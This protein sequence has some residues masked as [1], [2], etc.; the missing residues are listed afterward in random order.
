[1]CLWNQGTIRVRDRPWEP[2]GDSREQQQEAPRRQRVQIERPV[3]AR[4]ACAAI[5]AR[6]M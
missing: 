4:T 3:T 1:M 5:G 6:S 2:E